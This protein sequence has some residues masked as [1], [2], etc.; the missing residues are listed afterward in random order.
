MNRRRLL[1]VLLFM[2][3]PVFAFWA[4]SDATL[5]TVRQPISTGQVSLR[6]QIVGHW[7]TNPDPE[8]WRTAISFAFLESGRYEQSQLVLIAGMA[9]M[10][11]RD[12]KKSLAS[13]TVEGTWELVGDEIRVR[14]TQSTDHDSIEPFSYR[15]RYADGL[16]MRLEH[17]GEELDLFRTE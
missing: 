7:T 1:I 2:A 14:A 5:S 10:T 15:V 16:S 3:L 6:P 11:E 13:S 17:A 9:L 12:G 4:T 8:M